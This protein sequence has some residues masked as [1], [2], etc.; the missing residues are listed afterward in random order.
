MNRYSPGILN[1]VTE[2][3]ISNHV[4]RVGSGDNADVCSRP[5]RFRRPMKPPEPVWKGYSL[6]YGDTAG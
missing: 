4:W 1:D 3:V 2:I 5:H 6:G